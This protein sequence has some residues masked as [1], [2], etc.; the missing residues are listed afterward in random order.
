MSNEKIITVPDIGGFKEVAI[1]EVLVN[2]GDSVKA[3][4]SLITLE[5]DKAAM[6]IPSTH[7]GTVKALNVKVGDKVGQGSPILTLLL[8]EAGAPAKEP[9]PSGSGQG[10]G[11]APATAPATPP[12]QAQA[13]S[14]PTSAPSPAGRGQA[15]TEPS[16]LGR[17][18]GE[19]P[20]T[21]PDEEGAV[22]GKAHAS[23]AVRRFARELGADVANVK[24]TGPKG[25]IVKEDVQTYIKARLQAPERPAGGLALALPEAPAIDFA[26]YGLIEAKPLSRI[27]KLSGANL[28]RNWVTIPHV[29]CFE[30]A[31]I[32]DLEAFRVSLKAEA[33]K[34]KARLTLLPFLIKAVVA[35]LKAYPSFN[36][37]LSSNGEELILK[38][39]YHIGVAIDTP[40]GLV[41]PPVRDCDRKGV[42]DLAKELAELGERARGKKLRTP[43]LM[44]GSF[45]IS[46]LGGIGGTG[47]TPI[48]NAP[49]VAI[50][51]VSK[52]QT[53]PVWQNGQFVPRLMLPLS[54]S[55]DH[56]VIDGAE[57][58]RFC[59]Y[60]A[61]TL[62]DLR[63]VLL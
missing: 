46:S 9:S 18:Q 36:A 35:T 51:G 24:G 22:A 59:A 8:E 58:A 20:A 52:G 29:T 23:P 27:K 42:I 7:S 40:D 37:S 10:E 6:E 53:K 32:T 33:E 26:Q 57:A 17:G 12:P 63:R 45:T 19:G 49:E 5:S 15:A 3:E 41:V 21:I 25:R 34:Q 44:G 47:F 62:T 31:D 16:P 54:L 11:L 39:Y 48:I 55:F 13:E 14:A 56:R 43:E 2:V 61:Q 30:E 1:I 28:H 38:Q 50:L 60:L 4:E